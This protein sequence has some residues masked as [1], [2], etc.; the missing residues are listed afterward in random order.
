MSRETL[1]TDEFLAKV[2]RLRLIVK[3]AEGSGLARPDRRGGRH[4][5][6]DHRKY[7]PGDDLRYADWHL[8]GRH[9][10]LFLKEFAREETAEV[11]L[12]LDVSA[13]M[14]P[15]LDGALRMLAALGTIALARGDRVRVMSAKDG[16][17]EVA[18][19][20][21]GEGRRPALLA[22]LEGLRDRASGGTDLDSSLRRLPPR[23]GPGRRLMV[24]VSDL[25][26]ERDG[27]EEVARLRG[28]RT[29]ICWLGLEERRPG[30]LGRVRLASAEGGE[31]LAYVGA[32][33]AER[34][35]RELAR[36]LEELSAWYSRRGVRYL[37]APA[38]TSIEDLILDLLVR[39]GVLR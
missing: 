7:A 15:K 34:Y 6:T 1:F 32:D 29:V 19:P 11:V 28:D 25:L 20:L 2:E 16:E 21:E 23:S 13:S 24:L 31:L 17:L 33:E 5:F 22:H 35:E 14:A 10:R 18:R 37:L 12:V 3:R 38:E 4:E 8:Y 30:A 39:E 27:R 26:A 9:G 36:L